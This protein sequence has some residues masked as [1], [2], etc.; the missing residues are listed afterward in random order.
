MK[1]AQLA[2]ITLEYESTGNLD[3]P[4]VLLISPV[5]PDGFLS[6]VSEPVLAERYRLIRYHK[7]GWVGSTRTEGAVSIADHVADAVRLLEHLGIRKAH[8]VGHSSGAVVA[9]QLAIDHPALVDSLGLLEPSML[10]VPAADAFFKG[11][12][13]AFDAFA[14]GRRADAVAAFMTLASGLEWEACGKLLERR[15]PGSVAQAITDADTLFGVE[16][17]GLMQWSFNAELAKKVTCPTLSVHGSNTQ[18]LWVEVDERLRAWLPKIEARTI[19]GV[20]HLLHIQEP[21]PVAVA[22]ADFFTRSGRG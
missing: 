10:S 11:A 1:V 16:L 6:L 13:P 18:R 3:G 8:V 21:A 4:P 9:L 19:D 22:L 5:I 7:R 12:Q 14:A 17:P 15:M 20:G 2:G